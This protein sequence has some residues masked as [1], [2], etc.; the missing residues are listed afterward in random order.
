MERSIT[1]FRQQMDRLPETIR[2]VGVIDPQ[3]LSSALVHTESDLVVAV[4]SGGSLVT[5]EFLRL[6]RAYALGAETIC[7]TPLAW[8]GRSGL[9]E[10]RPLWLFSAGGNN[11][12]ILSTVQA[13]VGTGCQRLNLLTA[14]PTSPLADIIQKYAAGCVH[15][16]D[17]LTEK[18]GFLA[19]HS[20]I[21]S[22]LAIVRGF[23]PWGEKEIYHDHA[24]RLANA[25]EPECRHNRTDHA[26]VLLNK[27]HW[28]VLYDPLIIPAAIAMETS[29][30]ELGLA[31]VQMTDFRNFAHGR[32]VG[33]LRMQHATAIISLVTPRTEAIWNGIRELLPVAIPSITLNYQTP[34]PWS[35]LHAIGDVL[36][37]LERV[38]EYQHLDA[39]KPGVPE[40]GKAIYSEPSILGLTE[41]MDT[42]W[43]RKANI[44]TKSGWTDHRWMTAE[45][46]VRRTLRQTV[47]RGLLLDFDGTVVGNPQQVAANWVK[48]WLTTLL[49]NG[50]ILG[51]AS[52]RGG[53][54]TEALRSLIPEKYWDC[55]LVGYYN[56]GLLLP[57]SQSFDKE[58]LLSS[59]ALCKIIDAVET[60]QQIQGLVRD[61]KSGSLQ[62]VLYPEKGISVKILA[63]EILMLVSM[64]SLKSEVRILCSDHSVDI[65]PVTS[66]KRNV[67]EKMMS[68]YQGDQNRAILRVGD[69][70]NQGGNDY[71]ILDSPFGLSVADVSDRPE[72]CWNLLPQTLSGPEGLRYYSRCIQWVG[73]GNFLFDP[74]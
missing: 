51:I 42:P 52:G 66:S 7:L 17:G 19:V 37:I 64:L 60:H 43:K 59:P 41:G 57:L 53:S 49:D 12:D 68:Q 26:T 72:A 22:C 15:T 13:A 47:F 39:A 10:R 73:S 35:A 29:C 34:I 50:S 55:V 58:T 33:L 9:V 2:N 32:H 8:I 67:L 21:G 46:T 18:D 25:L 48:E 20:L 45:R 6:C 28:L 16:L 63:D 65:C 56:G 27:S 44:N 14:T 30:H 11:P 40:F 1:R 3:R 61:S 36:T 23:S 5:C 62:Y 74:I 70:G 69:K 38:S 71:D 31:S 54:L 24:L 4:G